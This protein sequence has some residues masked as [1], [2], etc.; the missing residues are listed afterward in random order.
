MIT[1]KNILVPTDFSEP[2]LHATRYA[3]ELARK[4]DAT[5]HL[6]NVIEDPVFYSPTFGGYAPD[7]SELEAYAKTGLDN[8][9]P[10]DEAEG[11]T[12]ERRFVHGRAF[13]SILRDARSHEIDLIVIGTHG[14]GFTAHLLLGSVAEKVVR[15]APCPVL[16][17]RPEGYQFRNFDDVEGTE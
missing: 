10:E 8:W 16:T 9:I 2:S 5:V 6:L 15:K 7:K 4:F 1:L 13:L 12:I 17:I 14:R 3:L 11:L